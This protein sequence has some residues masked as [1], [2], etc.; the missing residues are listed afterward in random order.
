[1]ISSSWKFRIKYFFFNLDPQW[2]N[3]R[4]K[5]RFTQVKEEDYHNGPNPNTYSLK[6]CFC[7][8]DESWSQVKCWQSWYYDSRPK[9]IN[10]HNKGK[11]RKTAT[12]NS[13][14]KAI[15]WDSEQ[16]VTSYRLQEKSSKYFESLR[17]D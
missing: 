6:A 1:L 10:K 2:K 14:C 15:N 17:W 4:T 11:L 9:G 5:L 16:S 8:K 3:I 7:L 12:L 13:R